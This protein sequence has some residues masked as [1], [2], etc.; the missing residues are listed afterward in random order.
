MLKENIEMRK[1]EL[2]RDVIGIYRNAHKLTSKKCY[3]KIGKYRNVL[4]R[5]SK[6]CYGKI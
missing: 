1:I 3:R 4:K 5:A 6:K 2:V